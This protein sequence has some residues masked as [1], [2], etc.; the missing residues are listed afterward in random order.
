MTLTRTMI[1][2]LTAGFLLLNAG[3]GS[4]AA[5]YGRGT[6]GNARSVAFVP[7]ADFNTRFHTAELKKFPIAAWQSLS[8]RAHADT[9]V[10]DP[11]KR[12][13]I[14]EIYEPLM[15]ASIGSV[16][17]MLL[18]FD[19]DENLIGG[20]DVEIWLPANTI[21][22]HLSPSPLFG[23][24]YEDEGGSYIADDEREVVAA[25]VAAGMAEQ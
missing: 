16:R 6:S 8:R 2:T 22:Y 1:P 10:T 23:L 3:C 12:Q 20:R 24:S 21:T 15:K 11:K 9:Y 7:G 4:K 13:Q 5:V 18:H 17:G 19:K 25:T 14:S